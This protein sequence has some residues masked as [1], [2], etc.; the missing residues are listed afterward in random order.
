MQ[1]HDLAMLVFAKLARISHEKRQSAG[2]DRFLLL[3]AERACLGGWPAV[4]DKCRELVLLSNPRHLLSRT[5]SVADCL[6]SEEGILYFPTL[7]RFCTFERAEYLLAG[8]ESPPDG[9]SGDFEAA[10]LQQLIRIDV[11][12]PG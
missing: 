5:P 10:S 6:R 12:S 11:V 2:R 7:H 9:N 4:A 3:T 1:N 8:Q